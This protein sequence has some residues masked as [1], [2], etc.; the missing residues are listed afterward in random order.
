MSAYIVTVS[1]PHCDPAAGREFPPPQSVPYHILFGRI[2]KGEIEG[3][4]DDGRL[5]ARMNRESLLSFIG[6]CCPAAG[7]SGDS[8]VLRG[9]GQLRKWI[10][11]NIPEGGEGIITAVELY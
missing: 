9:A 3:C 6:E 1:A 5:S 11:D 4:I 2:E 7:L 8:A 10:E